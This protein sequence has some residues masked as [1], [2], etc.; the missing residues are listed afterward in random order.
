LL[1]E[2]DT[3][4]QRRSQALVDLRLML[5]RSARVQGKKIEGSKCAKQRMAFAV[6]ATRTSHPAA[7]AAAP[8]DE[9]GGEE[10]EEN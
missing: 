7:A 2:A 9:E 3:I 6:N 10:E 8:A 4:L 1:E 5:R